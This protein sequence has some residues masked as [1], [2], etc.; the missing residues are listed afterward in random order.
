MALAR[1]ADDAGPTRARMGASP[2]RALPSAGAEAAHR[3]AGRPVAG[4]SRRGLATRGGDGVDGAWRR[5][6]QRLLCREATAPQRPAI[7]TAHG[8][9]SAA[10]PRGDT[11]G[12]RDSQAP[13]EHCWWRAGRCATALGQPTDSAGASER[14]ARPWSSSAPRGPLRDA[15]LLWVSLWLLCWSLWVWSPRLGS[16]RLGS[17]RPTDSSPQT[18][19][20]KVT[21]WL[22]VALI[23][24][25]LSLRAAM[26]GSFTLNPDEHA[27]L[28]GAPWLEIFRGDDDSLYHPPLA[29]AV[30]RGWA[31]VWQSLWGE[32]VRW[33]WRTPSVVAGVAA[34]LAWRGCCGPCWPSRP[35]PCWRCRPTACSSATSP[36]YA[37]TAAAFLWDWWR[38]TWLGPGPR[39][40]VPCCVGWTPG[41]PGC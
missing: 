38:P 2:F 39:C 21:P 20:H 26:V 14:Q 25:G 35:R 12:P 22:W 10:R 9:T 33:W 23:G 1:G 41:S 3:P 19:R 5:R 4:A 13:P 15:A 16:K 17:K 34:L 6:P 30:F 27:S 8:L 18:P 31:G 37:M 29:R 7:A 11:R 40:T 24:L 32:Q 28:D 36:P